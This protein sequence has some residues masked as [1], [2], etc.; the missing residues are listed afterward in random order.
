MCAVIYLFYR[1]I[2]HIPMSSHPIVVDGCVTRKCGFNL[3]ESKWTSASGNATRMHGAAESEIDRIKC[4][5]LFFHIL[6]LSLFIIIGQHASAAHRWCVWLTT[7]HNTR[8][9]A[10]SQSITRFYFSD[11]IFRCVQYPF[12]FHP[13]RRCRRGRLRRAGQ[14]VVGFIKMILCR[15]RCFN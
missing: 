3:T 9:Y 2:Y 5:F 4:L 8:I 6:L 15:K 14:S 7:S 1:L 13:L 11:S 12:H 10:F